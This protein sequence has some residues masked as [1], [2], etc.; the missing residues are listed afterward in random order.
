MH[1]PRFDAVLSDLSDAFR[2]LDAMRFNA[3]DLVVPFD[4]A[5][6]P[7]LLNAVPLDAAI[8]SAEQA[9]REIAGF[10]YLVVHKEPTHA[11][12]F[13]IPEVAP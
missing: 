13:R 11:V 8:A 10:L 7:V 6:Q 2:A 12:R 1:N 4:D 3:A 5:M 9:L